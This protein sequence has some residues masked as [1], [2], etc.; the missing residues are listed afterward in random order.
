MLQL[1]RPAATIDECLNAVRLAQ[2]RARLHGAPTATLASAAAACAKTLARV[3]D[4]TG[5]FKQR[6]SAF[7]V[8]ARA[9]RLLGQELQRRQA[10]MDH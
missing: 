7:H 4:T 9:E 2:D 1:S 5:H 6:T 3:A 10:N 8:L